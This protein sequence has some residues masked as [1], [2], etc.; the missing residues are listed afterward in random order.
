MIRLTHSVSA[1]IL[2]FWQSPLANVELRSVEPVVERILCVRIYI[3]QE[4][5]DAIRC[6]SCTFRMLDG[7]FITKEGC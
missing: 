1:A 6:T 5:S 3:P 4:R 7:S 2:T